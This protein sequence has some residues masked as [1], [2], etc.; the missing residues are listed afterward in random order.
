MNWDAIKNKIILALSFVL[1][2]VCAIL[3]IEH[4]KM[5][6]AVATASNDKMKQ[7]DAAIAQNIQDLQQQNVQAAQQV[8]VDKDKQ[9]SNQQILDF[10]NKDNK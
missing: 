6:A 9:L 2:V 5:A 8:V 1:L 7:K 10:L 3:G 4:E